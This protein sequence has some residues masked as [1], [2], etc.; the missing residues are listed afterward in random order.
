MRNFFLIV[1]F[2]FVTGCGGDLPRP[3]TSGIV[4]DNQFV[5]AHKEAYSDSELVYGYD[6]LTDEMGWHLESVT[7][8]RDV[9]DRWFVFIA[10]N[11][12]GYQKTNRIEV[13]QNDFERTPVGSRYPQAESSQ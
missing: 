11:D 3:I 7:K 13:T 8:Y 1:V 4:Y 12:Q 2:L 10:A 5:P 6:I 9:P